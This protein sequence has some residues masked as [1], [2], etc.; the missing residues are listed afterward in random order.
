MDVVFFVVGPV[1]TV[2][3]NCLF[4]PK[5]FLRRGRP[6]ARMTDRREGFR[7]EY[8]FIIWFQPRTSDFR[9]HNT[10]LVRTCTS[11]HLIVLGT[12]EDGITGNVVCEGC[13]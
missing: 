11:L 4:F 3:K 12:V 5:M 13:W 8:L 6:C 2:T 1:V 7:L 9:L 10:R